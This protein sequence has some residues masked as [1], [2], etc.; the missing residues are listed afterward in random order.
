[1]KKIISILFLFVGLPFLLP[2]QTA[3]KVFASMPES[4]LLTLT[5]INRLELVELYK[6]ELPAAVENQMGDSCFL[7][8][9]TDDYLQI[10]EEKNSLELIVLP[11]INDSKVICLIRTVCAPLCDSN[12]EFYTVNWKK[13]NADVFITPASKAQFIKDGVDFD[14]Q[15]VRNALVPLD[16]SLMQFRYDPDSRELL[17]YYNTPQYLGADDKEKARFYLKDA[18][19]AFKWNQTRFESKTLTVKNA[20]LRIL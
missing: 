9:M 8:H 7:T 19:V 18:P 15:K 16:I 17:Q 12:L 11:M 5:E 3:E 10:R 13:L 20:N 14:E 4:M 2:A 1:M 6:G